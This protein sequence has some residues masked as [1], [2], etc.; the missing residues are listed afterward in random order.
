MRRVQG[1]PLALPRWS[2]WQVGRWAA[3]FEPGRNG[4]MKDD[5][6]QAQDIPDPAREA[7]G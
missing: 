4:S 3:G 6:P 2:G 1:S 7:T 5:G